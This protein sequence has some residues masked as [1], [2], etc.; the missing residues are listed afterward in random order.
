MSNKRGKLPS[1]DGII[2]KVEKLE[3]QIENLEN[4]LEDK[5]TELE[6]RQTQLEKFMTPASKPK[7]VL[8]LKNRRAGLD[9]LSEL[10]DEMPDESD[11]PEFENS[12]HDKG[13]KSKK[14]HNK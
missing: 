5:R 7:L 13:K 3:T 4:R 12:T 14:K 1:V 2:T 10:L 11:D 8:W 6:Q 9:K